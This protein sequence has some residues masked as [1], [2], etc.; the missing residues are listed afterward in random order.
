MPVRQWGWQ[1]RLRHL[2]SFWSVDQK[3]WVEA[4]DLK[5]GMTLR[6]DDG[7]NVTVTDS[8]KPEDLFRGQWQ[9]TRTSVLDEYKPYL[10]ERWDEGCI[11][12]WRL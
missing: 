9:H 11:N 5:P 2:A 3:D 6:T 1:L 8:A 12:A 4:G 10:D 7:R